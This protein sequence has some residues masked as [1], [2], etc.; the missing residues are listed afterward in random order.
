VLCLYSYGTRL[1]RD[2]RADQSG[3]FSSL[4]GVPKPLVPIADVPLLTRWMGLLRAAQV[5]PEDVFVV[6]NAYNNGML[7]E[8][9]QNPGAGLP[10]Q[11]ILNDGSTNNETR[12]GAVRDLDLLLSQ[13][14]LQDAA[15][16]SWAGLLVIGGDTL[17]Y[18]DFSISAIL[19]RFRS[20]G[21]GSDAAPHRSQVLY[22]DVVDPRKNGI[23]EVDAATGLVSSFL[24]KPLPEETASRRAC[25]CFY[26]LSRQALRRV[27]PYVEAASSLAEVDAPGNLLKHLIALNTAAG[28]LRLLPIEAQHIRGRFDI[29]GL[30]TY[31]QC[32]QWFRE[33]EKKQQAQNQ[34]QSQE[35]QR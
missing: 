8:W 3:T 28:D 14:A 30:D 7:R 13:P 20:S 31:V 32:D 11:N 25:P 29:G 2:I 24:E 15:D 34:P 19:A 22:Y 10:L 17:F 5:Q 18:P 35:Q 1:E 16:G 6:G 4:I 21:D 33:Y 9:A 26:V 23:L 27:H 12:L